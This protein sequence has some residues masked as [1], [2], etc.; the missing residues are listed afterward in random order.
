MRVLVHPIDLEIGGSEIN[1]IDL[2]AA[3][4]DRGHD[5][6]VYSRPGPLR[7]LVFER[8]LRHIEAHF[9]ARPRPS[10]VA[11]WEL[12]KIVREEQ[13]DLVHAYEG[14]SFVEAFYGAR[15]C[16]GTPTLGTL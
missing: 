8:K 7:D 13:I 4:R 2:A 12:R 14:Y 11:V 6:I 10:P 1:A 5:V 3:V 16:C 9:P 15:L